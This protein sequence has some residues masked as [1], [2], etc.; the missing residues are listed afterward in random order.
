MADFSAADFSEDFD[1]EQE[2]P[3][4]PAVPHKI[5]GTHLWADAPHRPHRRP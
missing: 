2:E 4:A 5:V 3:E 1:I